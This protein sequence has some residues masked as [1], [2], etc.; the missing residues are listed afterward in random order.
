MSWKFLEKILNI[1]LEILSG[2]RNLL[3]DRFWKQVSY[4]ILVSGAASGGM[5]R[6]FFL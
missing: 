5:K 1:S 2:P 6:R 4:T 3:L